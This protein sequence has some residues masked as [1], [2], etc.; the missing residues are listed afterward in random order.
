MNPVQML[1]D[2]VRGSVV[3]VRDQDT[4]SS[5]I[6][7]LPIFKFTKSSIFLKNDVKLVHIDADEWCYML[8]CR[9]EISIDHLALAISTLKLKN[10][11]EILHLILSH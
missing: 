9:D 5:V 8:D 7:R 11:T 3:I 2:V 4:V 1:A 10:H 6:D